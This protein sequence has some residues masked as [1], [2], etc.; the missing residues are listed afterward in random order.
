MNRAL[1]FVLAAAVLTSCKSR[2]TVAI[3]VAYPPECSDGSHASVYLIRGASCGEC[4]CGDCLA[5]CSGERC[6]LGCPEGVCTVEQLDQGIDVLPD[7]PGNYALVYQLLTTSESGDLV[8]IAS[9]CV[10]NVVVGKDGTE[11]IDLMATGVW[12]P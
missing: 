11:D 4:T 9:A 7:E 5:A 12:C 10:D 6:T 1:A 3:D 8:E 2:G